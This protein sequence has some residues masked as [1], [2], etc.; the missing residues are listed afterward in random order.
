MTPD[1]VNLHAS[2]N[3]NFQ[4][5]RGESK[6]LVVDMTGYDLT[7]VTTIDWWLAKSPFVDAVDDPTSVLA[8]KSL[9]AGITQAINSLTIELDTI[10]TD[11]MPDQYYHE[12]KLTSSTGVQ[13]AMIGTVIIRMSL[14]MEVTP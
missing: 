9:D 10:D 4:V 5:F 14:E 3:Q 8:K 6:Q 1:P 11:Y 12:L 13:V 2:L 7:N